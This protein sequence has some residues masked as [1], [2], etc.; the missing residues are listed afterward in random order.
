MIDRIEC[1]DDVQ[2]ETV[3]IFIMSR[4]YGLKNIQWHLQE[5]QLYSTLCMVMS[6]NVSLAMDERLR[7]QLV[8]SGRSGDRGYPTS[9]GSR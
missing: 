7:L 3:L 6:L 1:I 4:R 5:W 9:W 2:N 8:F